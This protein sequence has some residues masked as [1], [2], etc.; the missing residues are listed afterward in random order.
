MILLTGATGK[1]GSELAKLVAAKRLPA[2]A[3]VRNAE[4]ASK[5]EG[6][7]LE[8][9]HGD[10]DRPETLRAALHGVERAFFL[11][12]NGPRQVQQG[13]NF[14]DA[15]TAAGVR[16]VVKVSGF[17]PDADSPNA[18]AR[19]HWETNAKLKA[20]GLAWTL[21]RPNFYMQNLLM[22]VETIR[23]HGRFHLNAGTAVCGMVHVSDI[24]AVG[25][26]CL[27]DAS[28]E[29]RDY[30]LTGP[31]AISFAEAAAELSAAAGRP[32]SY[33]PLGDA[34]FQQ[35]LLS[36]GTSDDMANA[37]T[38]TYKGVG[39]GLFSLVTDAVA[40]VA[41]RAPTPFADFAREL[42]PRLRD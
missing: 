21:L 13:A 4:Q 34:D 41:G 42:A 36:Q 11:P 26:V 20:S 33:V 6:L 30:A 32:V 29:G 38:E 37:L 25:A 28:H 8:I 2:R 24:A 18:N 7:G 3:L 10:F 40:L 31:A 17:L 12:A 19:R 35:H 22:F 14:I 23:E 9:V 15:A 5:L 27:T 16:H 39:E 1:V